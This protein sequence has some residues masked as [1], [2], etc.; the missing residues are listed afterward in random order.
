MDEA[1]SRCKVGGWEVHDLLSLHT[2]LERVSSDKNLIQWTP[3]QPV[4][5]LIVM[6]CLPKMKEAIETVRLLALNT[7][8]IS[9]VIRFYAKEGKLIE[10]AILLMVARKKF[11]DPI[12][13]QSK[14]GFTLKECMMFRQCITIELAALIDEEYSLMGLDEK[15]EFIAM[16]R[17]KRVAMISILHMLEIFERAGHSI[18][19]YLHSMQYDAPEKQVAEEVATLLLQAGFL[20]AVPSN[21]EF[22]HLWESGDHIQ[23]EKEQSEAPTKRVC[24]RDVH[25]KPYSL[26]LFDKQPRPN[27]QWNLIRKRFPCSS[28]AVLPFDAFWMSKASFCSGFPK[29]I[30]VQVKER[31]KGKEHRVWN[32]SS[33]KRWTFSALLVK[34]G[35]R[36]A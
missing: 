13:V 28:S 3:I 19:E 33:S 27:G 32:F 14:S 23:E 9:E 29:T 18:E 24:G 31:T 4:T 25:L 7:K 5:W 2:T 35:I 21:L 1:D 17:E 34:R 20:D 36:C 15:K 8:E 22:S 26:F 11:M 16:C 10:L 12:T 6:L 30:E